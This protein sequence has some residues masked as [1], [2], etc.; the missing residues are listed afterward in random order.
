MSDQHV[1]NSVKDLYPK[2]KIWAN[3]V[4]R[5]KDDQVFAIYMRSINDQKP[6]KPEDL[7]PEGQLTLF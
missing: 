3:K 5:M 4:D 6:E 1:R 7:V 2:S